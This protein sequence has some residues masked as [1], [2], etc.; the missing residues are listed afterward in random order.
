M[1]RPLADFEPYMYRCNSI[2]SSYFLD[3]THPGKD[4]ARMLLELSPTFHLQIKDGHLWKADPILLELPQSI[5]TTDEAC[6]WLLANPSKN[7]A[8]VAYHKDMIAA[9]AT[10]AVSDGGHW[11]IAYNYMEKRPKRPL[12]QWIYTH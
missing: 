7:C 6:D 4:V 3:S 1:L 2:V 8:E 10:H 9:R 11:A 5:R 12:R